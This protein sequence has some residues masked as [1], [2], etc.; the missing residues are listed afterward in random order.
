[1]DGRMD[2]RTEIHPYVLEDIIPFK[3]A[4]QKGEGEEGVGGEEEESEE[5]EEDDW[6]HQWSIRW[7]IS[8]RMD[9]DISTMLRQLFFPNDLFDSRIM[10]LIF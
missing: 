10:T 9:T 1:M 8:A 5:E 4:T 3:A 6:Q 2:R 7:K